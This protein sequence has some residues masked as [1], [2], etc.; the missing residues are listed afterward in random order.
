MEASIDLFLDCPL[1]V[2]HANSKS[3]DISTP[4]CRKPDGLFPA[5]EDCG[6]YYLCTK[7]RAHLLRCPPGLHYSIKDETCETPC[8]AQCNKNIGKQSGP[9]YQI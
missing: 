5:A 9:S 3:L 2:R 7:G 4:R 1:P 6:A 8:N